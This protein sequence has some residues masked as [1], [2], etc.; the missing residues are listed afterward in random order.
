MTQ[1]LPSSFYDSPGLPS[2]AALTGSAISLPRVEDIRN[3]SENYFP[4]TLLLFLLLSVKSSDLH[5]S[6]ITYIEIPL[7]L[8][9]ANAKCFVL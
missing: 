5:L 7:D 8:C 6:V 1:L 9:A 4:C 2:S 3:L